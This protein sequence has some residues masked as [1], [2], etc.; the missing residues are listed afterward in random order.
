V[1]RWPLRGDLAGNSGPLSPHIGPTARVPIGYGPQELRPVF[2]RL[3]PQTA[4]A[5][6]SFAVPASAG[7]ER[8]TTADLKETGMFGTEQMRGSWR[9]IRFDRTIRHL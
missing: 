1:K 8:C 6:A 9:F 4:A 2:V 3:P 5:G 7:R